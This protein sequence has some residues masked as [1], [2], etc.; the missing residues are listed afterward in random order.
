MSEE[1]VS[2]STEF[3]IF[4]TKPVQSSTL[5]TTETDYK[6]TATI[7]QSDLE[8]LIPA[9]NYT[10]IDLNIHLLIRGKLTKADGTEL[11]STD[12]TAMTNNLLH[13]LFS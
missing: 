12:Y 8:F 11:D 4:E 13:S 9:H 2:A 5:Y 6:P 7:D 3:D 10:Y 1:A